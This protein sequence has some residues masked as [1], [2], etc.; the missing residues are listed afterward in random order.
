MGD[1]D[2]LRAHGRAHAYNLEVVAPVRFG[3]REVHSSE[4]RRLLTLGE[5]GE[6]NRLLGREFAMSGLV[7]PGDRIGHDIG[8]PTVNLAVP[9]T[10][11]VPGRGIYAG[12]ADT[13]VGTTIVRTLT[14]VNPAAD[15]CA[16]SCAGSP[17]RASVSCLNAVCHR[18]G[19]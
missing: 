17:A 4:V 19:R 13:P 14:P 9:P 8:W 15:A 16:A 1:V 5:V 3:E 12:W 18:G 10:K 7:E 2:W 11:L 6:A